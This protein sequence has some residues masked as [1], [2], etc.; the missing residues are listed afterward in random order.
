MMDL[1]QH[2]QAFIELMQRLHLDQAF[3]VIQRGVI[4]YAL[5]IDPHPLPIGRAVAHFLF[6][7]AIRPLLPTPQHDQT[8]RDFHRHRMTSHSRTLVMPSQVPPHQTKQFPI[9]QQLIQLLQDR[10]TQS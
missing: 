9:L 6:R 10:I 5:V 1:R 7:L 3:Q 4:R 8:Q 2:Q